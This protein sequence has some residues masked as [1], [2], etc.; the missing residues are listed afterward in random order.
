MPETSK[1][2][3]LEK[4]E[5]KFLN[6]TKLLPLMTKFSFWKISQLLPMSRSKFQIRFATLRLLVE[7]GIILMP[8]LP[9]GLML[10]VF[11]ELSLDLFTSSS[12][13]KEELKFKLNQLERHPFSCLTITPI[14]HQLTTISLLMSTTQNTTLSLKS[15]FLQE[16]KLSTC[17]PTTT[18]LLRPA[19]V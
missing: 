16:L 3:L 11:Q 15:T 12:K 1:S 4:P 19:S 17:L 7:M 2:L 13:C 9:E 8:L 5:R 18:L 14:L 6:S 10:T